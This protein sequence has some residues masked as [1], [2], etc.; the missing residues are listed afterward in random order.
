MSNLFQVLSMMAIPAAVLL[1]CRYF[2][3]RG[4]RRSIP[5]SHATNPAT[6]SDDGSTISK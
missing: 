5:P 4:D 6:T 3:V 1:T 2:N